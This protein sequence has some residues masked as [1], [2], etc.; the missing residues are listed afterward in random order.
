MTG[1]ITK[2][3]R[4][5]KYDPQNGKWLRETKTSDIVVV[6]TCG[7][8]TSTG[9]TIIDTV[10][11]DANVVLYPYLFVVEASSADVEFAIVVGTSTQHS[12][13]TDTYNYNQKIEMRPDAPITKVSES[14][15][16]SINVYNNS[17]G[18]IDYQAYLTCKREPTPENLEPNLF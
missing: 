14:S 16:V 12:L 18:T 5:E 10:T 17:G 2:Y 1:D 6:G 4:Y 3:L 9:D 8:L 15:S 7:T 13:R 11:T